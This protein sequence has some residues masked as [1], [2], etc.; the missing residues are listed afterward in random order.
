[1]KRFVFATLVLMLMVGVASCKKEPSGS[2][3]EGVHQPAY[4]VATIKLNGA[5]AQSWDWAKSKLNSINDIANNINYTFSYTGNQMTHTQLAYSDGTT[6]S[7]RYTY[8]GD[9]LTKVEVVNNSRSDIT[10][11]VNHNASNQ[12]STIDVEVSD[13]FLISAGMSIMN[14]T[15]N[16]K[17]GAAR[18]LFSE[19]AYESLLTMA[20][21][22]AASHNN[23]AKYSIEN[24]HFSLSYTWNEDNV[25]SETFTGNVNA[26][27]TVDDITQIVGSDN[28]MLAAILQYLDSDADYPF[29]VDVERT[30]RYTYDEKYNPYWYC[31]TTGFDAQ[32]LSKNNIVTDNA[33]GSGQAT[34]T[35]TLPIMGT[36]TYPIR[37]IDLSHNINYTYTYGKKKYPTSIALSTGELYELEYTR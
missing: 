3:G 30:T 34:V 24:K 33:T 32:N 15:F 29:N 5:D 17:T 18:Y 22:Y 21:L 25:A 10:M 6:Q 31:W 37:T 7:I 13:A 28:A 23:N 26:T 1:M 27:I 11:Y 20:Q 8:S 19:N 35:V 14:G 36:N 2:F 16:F 9:Y 4:K 12:I